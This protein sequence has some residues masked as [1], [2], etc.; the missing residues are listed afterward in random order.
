MS[1]EVLLPKV[2]ETTPAAEGPTVADFYNDPNFDP[3]PKPG[4]AKLL[5]ENE[6]DD[7]YKKFITAHG[8]KWKI[9][10]FLSM[11]M[12][13]GIAIGTIFIQRAYPQDC[14]GIKTALWLSMACN[15]MNAVVN[16]LCMLKIEQKACSS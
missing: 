1:N 16:F 3:D 7:E 11:A 4:H 5:E 2:S 15:F 13:L 14:G 12:F 9:F 10:N 6:E 8:S